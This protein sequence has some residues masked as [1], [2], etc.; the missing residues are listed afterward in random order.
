M[1]R[2][3]RTHKKLARMGAV[4][5][6]SAEREEMVPESTVNEDLRGNHRSCSL[7]GQPGSK[8]Q[9]QSRKGARKKYSNL[10]PPASSLLLEP[11]MDQALCKSKSKEAQEVFS[12]P[13]GAQSTAEED[14]E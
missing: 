12:E 7:Q 6:P 5:S 2:V 1:G 10:S 11:P 4:R 3:K 14:G 8:T 13:P 9:C